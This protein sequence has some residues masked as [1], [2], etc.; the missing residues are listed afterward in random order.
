MT[1]YVEF[2]CCVPH[3]GDHGQELKLCIAVRDCYPKTQSQHIL[4]L[5]GTTRQ[6]SVYD[7]MPMLYVL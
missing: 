5:K 1:S 6:L 7:K 4:V 3:S 2:S